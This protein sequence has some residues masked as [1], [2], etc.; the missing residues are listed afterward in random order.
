MNVQIAFANEVE[1]HSQTFGSGTDARERRLCGL[2]HDVAQFAGQSH[3][4]AAFYE[5]RFDL[6]YL[7]SD[8]GPRQSSGESDLAL[9][10]NAL[11][12]KLDWTKHLAHAFG[13]DR[14]FRILGRRFGNELARQFA[15]ARTNLTFEIANASFACVVTNHFEN[16]FV[17]EVE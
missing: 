6:Q 7:A 4:A 2:L 8:L 12:T 9:R 15:A 10:S 11:L 3:A 13:I 17:G 1:T 16:A 5:C 14:V